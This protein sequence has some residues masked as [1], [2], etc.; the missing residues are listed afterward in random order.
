MQLQNKQAF[1]EFLAVFLKQN[2]IRVSE[3][4]LDWAVDRY[5]PSAVDLRAEMTASLREHYRE[6]LQ[7]PRR[8]PGMSGKVKI[9]KNDR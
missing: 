4:I 3:E 2:R 9:K 6:A 1:V 5:G 8:I 7:T